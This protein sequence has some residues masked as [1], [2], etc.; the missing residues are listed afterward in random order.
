MDQLDFIVDLF[1]ALGSLDEL[2]EVITKILFDKLDVIEQKVKEALKMSLK[3]NICCNINPSLWGDGSVRVDVSEFDLMNMFHINPESETGR[4]CYF[5]CYEKLQSRDMNVFLYNIITTNNLEANWF[6]Y[7]PDEYTKHLTPQTIGSFRFN[8]NYTDVADGLV[9][10]NVITMKFNSVLY[11]RLNDWTSDYIDSVKF[12]DKESFVIQ[13][14]AK[15]FGGFGGNLSPEQM[16]LQQQLETIMSRLS[17]C[18]EESSGETDD[19]FF[20]FDNSMYS[21]MLEQAEIKKVQGYEYDRTTNTAVRIT[22]DDITKAFEGLEQLS[23][24]EEQKQSFTT[25]MN[26]LMDQA[27][28]GNPDVSEND[29]DQFRKRI[30][31]NLLKELSIAFSMQ[32]ISPKMFLV[33]LT[34]MRLMGIDKNYDAVTFIRENLNLVNDVVGAIKDAILKEMLDEIKKKT[35]SLAKEVGKE[36]IRDN[37]IKFAKQLTSLMPKLP[38]GT[39]FKL[40]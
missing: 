32:L 15:I 38:G 39:I 35:I 31:Q 20:T 40:S 34:N 29:K 37:A 10:D 22:L 5:D 23:N 21:L 9:H 28:V 4:S 13:L 27:A 7:I 17:T 12:W 11:K 3:S 2:Q 6:Q 19:S 18:D 8:E 30:L 36:L 16:V 14:L 1:S 25:G 33:I 26:S 24:L